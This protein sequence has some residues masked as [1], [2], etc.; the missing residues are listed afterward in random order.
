MRW[1]WIAGIVLGV[2]VL[3]SGCV[4]TF[5]YLGYRRS[6]EFAW[7]EHCA[8]CHGENLEGTAIGA[9]L[10]G[11]PLRHGESVEAVAR[12]IREGDLTTGMPAWSETLSADQIQMLALLVTER[13]A[14][15]VHTDFKVHAPLVLPESRVASERHGFRVE[16][17]A[18]GLH[19]YPFSIAPLGDGRIL[20]TEKMAG[21]R[22][23]GPDGSVSELVEGTPP[24]HEDA[25][26]I[27]ALQYGSGWLMDVAP[28]PDYASNGWIYLHFGDRCRECDTSMNKLVRG[29]LE[30]GRWV[31][32]ETIWEAA[33]EWY[34]EVPET[35]AGGR[36][37]FDD[38]GHVFLSIG[39]KGP[40]NYVG[41]QDLASPW[42]K[43]L[44][45]SDDGRVP[46]DNP[47]VDEPGALAA[48]WTYGHRSPQG[49]EVDPRTGVLWGTEMGPRGGDEVNV[50]RPGR[51]Y[52]WPL[53]S[54]GMDYDGTPAEYGIELGIEPD[55]DAIEQPVVDLTPA[56]AVASFV[57][58]AG[59]AFPEWQGDLIVGTLRARE[60]Y[61]MEVEG[62]RVVHRETLLDDFARIRD[63][64]TAPDGTLLLL[65]EH[66]DGSRIVRLAPD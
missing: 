54:L 59:A 38:A 21:L 51:N 55:L 27:Y 49:L 61:R 40:G 56:P 33:P 30:D 60:L 43:I 64:E 47:F 29:R 45:L 20:V 15:Y 3:G 42:G 31:D 44:R 57:V 34:N 26:S 25:F 2:L 18:Q 22:V 6:P 12:V 23:V 58:Y 46:A 17:V 41:P 1:K 16:P 4:A 36:I 19:A 35:G 53:V 62:D 39:I 32:Q 13:R 48:I 65:L 28:H 5:L 37:A 63:I 9:P 11:R 24:A 50:L 52:G 10:V 7:A 8:V 14:G 66:G